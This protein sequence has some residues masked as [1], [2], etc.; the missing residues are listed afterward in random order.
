MDEYVYSVLYKKE[1]IVENKSYFFSPCYVVKGIYDEENRIFLDEFNN[2]R[3]TYSDINI[4][5]GDS[6]YCVGE[7]YTEEELSKKF[8]DAHGL[9]DSLVYL[10]KEAESYA[11][12]GSYQ[13]KSTHIQ[14][15]RTKIEEEIVENTI[16]F[17]GVE[18][19]G[20]SNDFYSQIKEQ[21]DGE[22]VLL[23]PNHIDFLLSTDNL[24]DIKKLVKERSAKKSEYSSELAQLGNDGRAIFVE[25]E[26]LYSLLDTND[27][28]NIRKELGC[29]KE[30]YYQVEVEEE[31]IGEED[32]LDS[33]LKLEGK[34]HESIL[35]SSGIEELR[36]YLTDLYN[37]YK[38]LVCTLDNYQK[39]GHYVR[40]SQTYFYVYTAFLNELL[41]KDDF[42]L[43]KMSY[44]KFYQDTRKHIKG[45]EMEWKKEK[46]SLYINNFN[47]A[48]DEANEKLNSL[49]GLENVK[50]AIEEIIDTI[51]FKKRTQEDLDFEIGSKHMVFLGNPG[52]GKTTIA[53]I[54]APLLYELGYLE[55]NK[56]SFVSSQ[57]LIG[58]Y[59]GQTA[60]KT[61]NVI[62]KNLGGVIV[63][64]EAYILAEDGQEYGN[65]AVTVILKEMEYNRTMFIFAGY[66]E[67]M[68]SFIKMNS[69]LESRIGTFL[70]FFDYTEEELFEIFKR[71]ID[72]VNTKENRRYSLSLTTEALNSVKKI[73][74][75]AKQIPDFGNGRFIDKLFDTI[76]KKHA[77]NTRDVIRM[78]DLYTITKKD[79][80]DS[81]LDEILFCGGRTNS[82]YSSS[83][84]GFCNDI[85]PRRKTYMKTR[86][87]VCGRNK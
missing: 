78:E 81:I 43:I 47:K 23:L 49:V 40:K 17:D 24:D 54:L 19:K 67:E 21:F 15:S 20:I 87:S 41:K 64:D 51:I 18:E 61:E 35:K 70:E 22:V 29:I 79:I 11:T 5:G 37:F 63:L 68:E 42:L 26:A 80:P 53:N 59:V 52:T 25:K 76:C 30:A 27:I 83:N 75:E 38:E 62:R 58:K 13:N 66:K 50:R 2:Q 39:E 8:P 57:D 56:V 44:I 4:I 60:P 9:R 69:G 55:S 32:N 12:M 28:E 31:I 7:V 84:M 85:R 14:I 36:E 77:R 73:I 46:E 71:K 6:T 74:K 48:I 33:V 45:I 3:F 65:E 82:L 16:T 10:L 86:Q 34:I 72:K 1:T